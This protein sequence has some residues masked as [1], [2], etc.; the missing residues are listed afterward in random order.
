MSNF[1]I[2]NI[3]IDI[4]TPP[5]IIAEIGINHNGKLIEAIKIADEAIKNGADIIKHQTHVVSDE[6]ALSAKKVIPGNSKKSIYEIIDNCSLNE[7]DEFKLMQHVKR[8]K[9]LF[10]STPFSRAATDRLVKFKVAGFKIG[11]GECN[12]YP[13]VDYIAS[14]RKPIILSTGMNDIRSIDQAVRIFKNYK[15]NFALMH[16]TNLYPTPNHLTR[17]ECIQLLK[18]KY[19]STIIGYSDHTTDN[20]AAL[21]SV[22]LGAQIIERHFTYSKKNSGPDISSSMDGKDLRQIKEASKKIFIGLKGEKKPLPEEK[23]TINFAFASVAIIKNIKKGEKFSKKNIFTLRPYNG[24]FKVKDYQKLLG[25][26]ASRNLF[27]GNQLKKK[28]VK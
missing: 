28:D 13:L 26:K 7:D 12:N 9:K 10:I 16:C 2:G 18:K 19:P 23:P 22:A 20:S 6:M 21:G 27:A 8:K 17:L 3:K 24:Y 15:V 4:N 25:K 14:K 5:I 1:K 11:S